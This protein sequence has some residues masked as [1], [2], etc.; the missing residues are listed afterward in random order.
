[1]ATSSSS[2]FPQV[3]W[4]D[5]AEPSLT[6]LQEA[7][8][9]SLSSPV[10]LDVKFFAFSRRTLREDGT[11]RVDRPRS[12][13][14]IGSVLQ[15]NE[16][17]DKLLSSGFS[18]STRRGSLESAF[19]QNEESY[20]DDYDYD[21]DS[22]LDENEAADDLMSE[23]VTDARAGAS[24]TSPGQCRQVVLRDVAYQTLRAFVFYL[25]TQRVNFLPLRS[26]GGT[27]R[28]AEVARA[29]TDPKAVPPCSPKSMY[30]LADKY[31]IPELQRLAFTAIHSKLSIK[32]IVEESFSKFTARYEV[33]RDVE[34]NYLRSNYAEVADSLDK[35]TDR[36]VSGELPH[37]REVLRRLL[38]VKSDARG[39]SLS[40][41]G[42]SIAGGV[43][44]PPTSRFVSI[45][46]SRWATYTPRE[47]YNDFGED[48]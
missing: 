9:A 47:A 35:I 23:D 4:H 33:V 8:K 42:Y 39:A 24:D 18:E 13:L 34:I 41:N 21:E 12:V 11:I 40:G 16:Y 10:F 26:E 30:R 1:M 3:R 44:P 27:G 5:S 37:A 17:F 45:A 14:A 36:L 46:P 15:R 43:V 28:A 22:D 29:L 38:T 20:L 31:E 32:N 6:P 48:P 2:F 7:L 19:P 25:Y